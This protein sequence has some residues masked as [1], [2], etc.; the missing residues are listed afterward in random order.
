MFKVPKWHLKRDSTRPE[1]HQ[2]AAGGDQ[3]RNRAANRSAQRCLGP[4]AGATGVTS[5]T[6]WVQAGWLITIGDY[7]LTL[8]FISA[9]SIVKT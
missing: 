2:P 3:H 9:L 1:R 4:T 8:S 5:E 7:C 6:D